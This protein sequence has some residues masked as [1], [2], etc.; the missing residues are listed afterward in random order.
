[1][2]LPLAKNVPDLGTQRPGRA[3][4]DLAT[5]ASGDRYIPDLRMI[6]RVPALTANGYLSNV[7]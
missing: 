5:D 4:R 2:A 6:P 1:M 3:S 7:R